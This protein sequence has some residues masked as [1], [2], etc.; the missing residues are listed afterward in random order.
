M[1]PHTFSI[2]NLFNFWEVGVVDRT[3]FFYPQPL[4]RC[5]RRCG[6]GLR[7][8]CAGGGG[9]RVLA[10]HSVRSCGHRRRW[11]RNGLGNTFP[12]ELLS[13]EAMLV[14]GEATA[15][16]MASCGWEKDVLGSLLGW[17]ELTNFRSHGPNFCR[18]C[19]FL[20]L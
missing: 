10:T 17:A 3:G 11:W 6:G 15:G 13:S 4:L 16:T 19:K 20:I 1:P 18:R 8:R 7:Q 5:G 2:G 9:G 14:R 12:L